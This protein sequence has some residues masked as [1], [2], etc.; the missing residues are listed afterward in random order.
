MCKNVHKNNN[1]GLRVIGK[2][3]SNDYTIFTVKND[4][5]YRSTTMH[6]NKI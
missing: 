6:R 4:N 3:K 5:N 2:S 1:A